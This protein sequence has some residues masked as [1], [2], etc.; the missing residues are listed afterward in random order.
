MARAV[1][2]GSRFR[3]NPSSHDSWQLIKSALKYRATYHRS[4]QLRQGFY[5]GLETNGDQAPDP[6]ERTAMAA[7]S[8][9]AARRT[10]VHGGA[11]CGALIPGCV[12]VRASVSAPLRRGGAIEAKKVPHAARWVLMICRD[13]RV[14][15]WGRRGEAGGGWGEGQKN[16]VVESDSFFFFFRRLHREHRKT[17][18]RLHPVRSDL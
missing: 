10:A 8:R 4:G 1:L 15:R 12:R 6:P 9:R 2:I 7:R 5:L 18:G 17:P 14:S 11:G 16:T 13:L 3:S